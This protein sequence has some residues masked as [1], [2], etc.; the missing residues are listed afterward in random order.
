MSGLFLLYTNLHEPFIM[1][2]INK[3]TGGRYVKG[4]V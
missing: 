1:K 4:G 3:H 2:N